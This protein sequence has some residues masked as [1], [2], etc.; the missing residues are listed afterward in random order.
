MNIPRQIKK[1][2]MQALYSDGS[3]CMAAIYYIGS[4][5]T[6]PRNEQLLSEERT[7]A[8]FQIDSLK[9]ERLVRRRTDRQTDIAK[10]TQLVLLIIYVYI[11]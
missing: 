7:R 1:F 5:S 9:T 11:L 3:V 2:S 4:I 6:V 8:K 10:S